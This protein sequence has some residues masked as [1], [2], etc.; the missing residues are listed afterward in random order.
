MAPWNCPSPNDMFIK[1]WTRAVTLFRH[2][3]VLGDLT[4]LHAISE[5]TR[6]KWKKVDSESK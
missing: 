1:L 4:A 6:V 2:R 3:W 5:V